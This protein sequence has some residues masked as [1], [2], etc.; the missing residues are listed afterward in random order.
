MQDF[1]AYSSSSIFDRMYSN[2]HIQRSLKF[3]HIATDSRLCIGGILHIGK[4][5]CSLF[6]HGVHSLYR[7]ATFR[8]MSLFYS[9]LSTRLQV[10]LSYLRLSCYRSFS[11][12][13][14]TKVV[15]Y[16]FRSYFDFH[17]NWIYSI[18]FFFSL[19]TYLW[20][21]MQDLLFRFYIYAV[22]WL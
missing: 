4:R 2:S 7:K 16:L 20:W 11:N 21:K 14:S 3:T 1:T 9:W 19:C 17:L 12:E 13:A 18:Y 22:Q 8:S 6:V 5:S 15:N 10:F